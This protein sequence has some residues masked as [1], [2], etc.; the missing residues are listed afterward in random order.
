MK[1]TYKPDEVTVFVGGVEIKD[2]K[3]EINQIIQL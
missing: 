1:K 2:F 3:I